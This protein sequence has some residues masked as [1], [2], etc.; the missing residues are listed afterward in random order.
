MK[1]VRDKKLPEVVIIHSDIFTDHRGRFLESYRVSDLAEL[2]ILDS[3]FVQGNVSYSIAWTL[4]GMHYQTVR[5]QG[6]LMRAIEGVV[7][8]VSIDMR[9]GSPTFGK[10]TSHLLNSSVGNA[11]WC[12]PGFA[13]GF[14]T[15][16]NP[17]VV[18]YECSTYYV[19]EYNQ[20]LNWHDPDVGIVWALPPGRTPVLSNKDRG[21]SSLKEVEPVKIPVRGFK[22]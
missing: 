19:E 7:Q 2:G 20:S 21:A 22:S 16:G 4:R 5:P 18:Y 14:L 9:E 6:K 12:P 8:Q 11:V 10:W 3:G 13:N 17:A 1:I 15:L